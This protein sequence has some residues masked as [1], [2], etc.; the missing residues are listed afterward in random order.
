M[1]MTRAV[2]IPK[3]V[4]Q[5]EHL[6]PQT[7]SAEIAASIPLMRGKLLGNALQPSGP[8]FSALFPLFV[9][10]QQSHCHCSAEVTEK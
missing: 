5:L 1:A 7:Q 9:H 2:T 6:V 4:D 3:L 10:L 8:F